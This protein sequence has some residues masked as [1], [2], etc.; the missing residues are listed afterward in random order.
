M[1]WYK[2]RISELIAG[3]NGEPYSYWRPDLFA[4]SRDVRLP[5]ELGRVLNDVAVTI[6]TWKRVIGTARL[7]SDEATLNAVNH[8]HILTMMFFCLQYPREAILGTLA[9]GMPVES[10]ERKLCASLMSTD[11]DYRH[12]RNSIAHGSFEVTN[13]G[14]GI[15]FTDRSWN[16]YKPLRDVELDSLIVFDILMSAFGAKMAKNAR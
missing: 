5:D 14:R 9:M 4:D 13:D 10:P 16:K 15:N 2:D 7:W 8:G 3:K 11:S 12:I 6:G 1:T